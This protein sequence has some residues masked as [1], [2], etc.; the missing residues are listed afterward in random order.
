MRKQKRIVI[1]VMLMGLLFQTFPS[2]PRAYAQVSAEY[3]PNYK[4][5]A[6]RDKIEETNRTI[7]AKQKNGQTVEVYHFRDLLKNYNTLFQYLP[8]K[9]EY[10]SVYEDCR[11]LTE[12]LAKQYDPNEYTQYYNNCLAP[13]NEIFKEIANSN[14]VRAKIS[15]KPTEG[16]APL[17]VTFDGR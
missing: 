14:T 15:G 8:Q 7:N 9:S 10:K 16:S 13:L 2:I 6:E 17:T 5:A 1:G 11:I 3:K 4:F 12:S